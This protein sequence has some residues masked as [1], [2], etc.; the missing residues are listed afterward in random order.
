[1]TRATA[2]LSYLFGAFTT[3]GIIYLSDFEHDF[4]RFPNNSITLTKTSKERKCNALKTLRYGIPDIGPPVI[5]NSEYLL[6]YD[7]QRR[8]PLWVGEHLT[9][10]HLK[11]SATRS[12][13][14]FI[15]DERLDK[16]FQ[17]HNSD[18]F[19]SGLSRG[20]MAAAGNYKHSVDSMSDTFHLTN[21]LPQDYKNNSGYWNLLEIHVRSLTEKYGSTTVFC[22]PAFAP[23]EQKDG[24]KFIR[25]Q[26]VGENEVSVPTHLFKV[27]VVERE[28]D[29]PLMGAFLMPNE[30]IKNQPL[31]NF[32]V[33]LEVLERRTGML[34][35]QKLRDYDDLCAAGECDLMT[36]RQFH[37]YVTRRNLRGSRSLEELEINW[38]RLLHQDKI[39]P[40]DK[41]RAIYENKKKSL[42]EDEVQRTE[43]TQK[44]EASNANS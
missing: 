18:Y 17:S 31:A 32:Q 10:E 42:M 24:K 34:F 35:L 21:I 27:I 28:D 26:V 29:F 40:T 7:H 5:L 11:G 15:P 16:K 9:R 3:G 23:V 25:Y 41:I 14:K 1:M 39:V 2:V 12:G 19:R 36:D 20:H 8:I 38:K 44:Q 22:G 30:E 37:V 13:I 43:G 33:P 4:I 6:Q